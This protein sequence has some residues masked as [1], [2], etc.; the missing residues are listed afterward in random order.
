MHVS[1]F[2]SSLSSPVFVIKLHNYC[3][4]CTN[5]A[6]V[7]FGYSNVTFLIGLHIILF[8][9][10]LSSDVINYRFHCIQ[11]ILKRDTAAQILKA[12]VAESL[13]KNEHV[14]SPIFGG[15]V[16]HTAEW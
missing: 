6:G 5:N 4:K 8:V 16:R 3:N 10:Q 2:K 15:A 13:Y 9:C 12:F 7:H 1:M 14:A 11:L